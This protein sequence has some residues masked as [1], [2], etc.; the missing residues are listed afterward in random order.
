MTLTNRLFLLVAI[1]LLPAVA[2]QGYNEFDLRR[3][4]EAEVRGQALQ[5]AQLAA[6]ELDQII[7]GVASVLTAVAEVP[8]VLALDRGQCGTFL[9]D[10]QREVPHLLSIGVINLEGRVACL[11]DNSPSDVNVADRP[12]FRSAIATGGLVVGDYTDGRVAQRPVLPIAR[13]IRD[14]DDRIVGVVAAALDLRW[15]S[16][17][18]AERS[19]PEGDSVTVADRNG[20]IIARAPQPERFVGTTIPEAFRHLLTAPAPGSL[21]VTS[22]DGTRRVL[23]YIPVQSGPIV[24]LYVSAGLAADQ[25]F[26]TID[27]ATERGAALIALGLIGA[28]LAAWIVGRRFFLQPMTSLLAAARRWRTGD[29]TA[30]A[31]LSDRSGE[32]SALGQEFDRMAAEIARREAERDR[33]LGTAQ[34][35]EARLRAV[36]ESLP[37]EFWVI[38]RDGRYV[39]QNPVSRASWGDRIGQRPEETDTPPALLA[40]W[41]DNNRRALAGEIVRAE[42]SWRSDDEIRH[43]EKIIA[44]ILAGSRVLGAV[45]LNID[46]TERHQAQE[47]QRLLVAELNHRVRN[48]LATVGAIVR[49]TLTDGRPLDDARDALR[50]RLDALASTYDLLT[51]SDWRGALISVIATDALRPFGTRARIDGADVMLTPQAAQTI[52]IILHELATNAAKYGALSTNAGRVDLTIAIADATEGARLQIVWTESSGPSVAAPVRRGLGRSVIEDLAVR[53]LKAT[54]QVEFRPEGLVYRLDAPLGA[55]TA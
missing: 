11:H 44:P 8:S 6:S 27:R 9:R 38:D 15:L 18:L 3:S 34:E 4:R 29:F 36:V 17:H 24:G 1:A 53:Q 16:R 25:A 37:F 10:L 13:P 32:F 43:V 54:A 46:V 55:L 42:Q 22:Q 40:G 26:A 52:G 7:G 12:Y 14:A 50:D 33:A 21:E 2:I 35:S 47:R 49:L 30:R 48:M 23:G 19:L 5:Q 20:I 45:G 41:L 31:G 51:A 28:L 39:L